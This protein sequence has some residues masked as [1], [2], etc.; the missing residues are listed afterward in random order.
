MNGSNH[1]ATVLICLAA[2]T[3]LFAGAQPH[4]VTEGNYT[5]RSSTVSSETI[6]ASVAK[7]HGFEQ[8]P[9]VFILNITVMEKSRAGNATLPAV[10]TVK[11]RDLTGRKLP[12]DMKVNHENGFVSYYGT[13]HRL[14]NQAL[15][16]DITAAPEG[17]SRMLTMR[18]RDDGRSTQTPEQQKN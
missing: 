5:L 12:I 14:P 10:L 15:S 13:Y 3:P 18:Y 17:S 16:F 6:P 9:S 1:I 4:E 2:W 8:G 11:I 7:A